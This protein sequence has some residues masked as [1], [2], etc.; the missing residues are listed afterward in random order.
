[1]RL[2]RMTP[3]HGLLISL[4]LVLTLVLSGCGGAGTKYNE[5]RPQ[6]ILLAGDGITYVG[7]E[8]L[9]DAPNTCAGIDA[10][11]RFT[12]NNTADNSSLANSGKLPRFVNNWVV[13][14]A[15]NY[16]LKV[17]QIIEA[18]TS[19]DASTRR[20][21]KATARLNQIEQQALLL[22]AYKSGDMLVISGGSNDILDAVTLTTLPAVNL[23][24]DQVVIADKIASAS[25]K[26]NLSTAEI[27]RVFKLAQDYIRLGLTMI[28]KGHQNIFITAL[29]DFSNSPNLNAI[30]TAPC[31]AGRLKSAIELFNA[32][33]IT[34]VGNQPIYSTG[35][36]RI[37]IGR[38]YTSTDGAYVNIAVPAVGSTKLSLYLLNHLI[39]PSVCASSVSNA[40]ASVPYPSFTGGT[41]N[42]TYPDFS[43]CTAN[44][45]WG[46][47]SVSYLDGN[48]AVQ[49]NT[50]NPSA[51]LADY[52]TNRGQYIYASGQYL[53]PAAH[54]L[55]GTV[56]YTFMIGFNGW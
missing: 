25:V 48:N 6:R 27:H 52:L 38:G 30:C 33:L 47:T 1:M 22:P 7:C 5:F 14:L 18:K 44:G 8:P 36:P 17:N 35:K 40:S 43:A 2:G 19:D 10:N 21:H 12:V 56:F 4:G 42:L 51:S 45:I 16:G 46:A 50:Y 15:S 3:T 28:E 32:S 49:T 26:V 41:T 11:D 55:I 9:L 23:P 54:Q 31:T 13:Q 24:G 39:T 37:L 34:D 29:Y 53:A 20:I